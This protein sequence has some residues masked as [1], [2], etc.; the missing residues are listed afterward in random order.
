AVVRV[1]GE[2]RE[3]PLLVKRLPGQAFELGRQAEAELKAGAPEIGFRLSLLLD[4]PAD[5]FEA[6]ADLAGHQASPEVDADLL[7]VVQRAVVVLDPFEHPAQAPV[8]EVVGEDLFYRRAIYGELHDEDTPRLI[9]SQVEVEGDVL[10]V[11]LPR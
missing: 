6:L 10:H 8:R 5:R 3:V 2:E 1:A 11:A 9:H 4:L 7:E